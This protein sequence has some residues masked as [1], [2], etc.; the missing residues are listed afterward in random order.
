[1]IK[2]ILLFVSLLAITACSKDSKSTPNIQY[3]GVIMPLAVDN[4][5][6][7]ADTTFEE[8]ITQTDTTKIG[9]TGHRKITHQSVR[10]LVYYW[11]WFE[12]PEDIPQL[13]KNLVRNEQEGLIYYG[14]KSGSEISDINR[15]LFIKYPAQVDDQWIYTEDVS[16]RC[17]SVSTVFSTPLA[18]FDCHVY[19]IIP[20]S[21]EGYRMVSSLL[22]YKH[23]EASRDDQITYLYYAPEVGYVG[24]TVMQGDEE[25][26]TR[27]LIDYQ[28]KTPD[29]RSTLRGRVLSP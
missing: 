27:T 16:L 23:F 25:K 21:E 14:Q 3:S 20:E 1:M 12:M 4:Y 2:I 8:T 28:V 26:F 24:M 10:K 15:K 19:Q 7:Y 18:D 22:N 17:V 11:N 9:I 29:E 13:R 6:V 5:W